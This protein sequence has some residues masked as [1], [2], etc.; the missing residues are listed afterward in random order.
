MFQ[1]Q[2]T[3]LLSEAK[4]ALGEDVTYSELRFVFQHL[5]F[6]GEIKD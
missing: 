1:K 6:K 2:E 4:A 3:T 5:R